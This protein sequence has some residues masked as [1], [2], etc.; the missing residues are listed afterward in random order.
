MVGCGTV[1]WAVDSHEQVRPTL[2]RLTGLLSSTIA[3]RRCFVLSFGCRGQGREQ[4]SFPNGK[5]TKSF[6]KAEFPQLGG[7]S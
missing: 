4:Q 7:Y 2:P 1:S 6:W 5:M 3:E